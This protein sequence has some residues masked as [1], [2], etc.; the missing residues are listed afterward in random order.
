M[1]ELFGA[2][3]S[4]VALVLAVLFGLSLLVL[5]Y[6]LLRNPVLVRMAVRN[7]PRRRAQSLLI[8]AGMMLATAIISSA[9]TTGD[10]VNRS[11]ERNATEDLLFLDQVVRLDDDSPK[12]ETEAMPD[13]FAY[14]VFEEMEPHLR[15]DPDVDGVLPA[16]VERVPVANID[17]Q[18]FEVQ[19][20]LTGVDPSRPAGLARSGTRQDS[21]S[22]SPAWAPMT[23]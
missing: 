15:G 6:I 11:I 14:R 3:M 5:L 21:P 12:W 18:Q 8:V 1:D 22:T 2:P 7:I 13:S 16:Y 4:S 17:S 10:S 23:S 19:G 9:F 20:L